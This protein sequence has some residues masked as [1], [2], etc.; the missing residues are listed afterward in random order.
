M[1]ASTMKRSTGKQE[2]L[3]D[4]LLEPGVAGLSAQL[5][6]ACTLG[7]A[8]HAFVSDVLRKDQAAITARTEVRAAA[9]RTLAL[10]LGARRTAARRSLSPPRV[11]T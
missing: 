6:H 1:S 4:P 10:T 2:L 5:L 3:H 9:S 11:A 7:P 8:A